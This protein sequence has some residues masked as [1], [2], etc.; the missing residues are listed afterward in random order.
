[1]YG[2]DCPRLNSSAFRG[3]SQAASHFRRGPRKGPKYCC[4]MDEV[5]Q[6]GSQCGT[7]HDMVFGT[8]AGDENIVRK[9]FC[10]SFFALF[11]QWRLQSLCTLMG[12]DACP[13]A[14]FF[15]N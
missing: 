12:A 10:L 2:L 1:M 13:K 14:I 7:K 15:C 9:P 11:W 5:P 3:T 6:P 4:L 8:I